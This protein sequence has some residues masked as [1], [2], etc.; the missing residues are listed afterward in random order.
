MA[1][2]SETKNPQVAQATTTFLKSISGGKTLS[3]TYMHGSAIKLKVS[4]FEI[5]HV[6]SIKN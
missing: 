4:S 3:L 2:S 5:K 6:S 1:V